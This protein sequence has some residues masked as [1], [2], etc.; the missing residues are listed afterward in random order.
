MGAE[1]EI[2]LVVLPIL[3]P[4]MFWQLGTFSQ[5]SV[6]PRQAPGAMCLVR[7]QGWAIGAYL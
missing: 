5:G 1:V 7:V 2:F 3:S 4:S 6:P